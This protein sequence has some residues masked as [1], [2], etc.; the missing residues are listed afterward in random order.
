MTVTNARKLAR[1]ASMVSAH[2]NWKTTKVFGLHTV[3]VRVRSRPNASLVVAA[4]K[5]GQMMMIVIMS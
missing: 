2:M 3:P 4:E 1:L 5:T